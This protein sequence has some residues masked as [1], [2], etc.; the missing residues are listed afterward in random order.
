MRLAA[1]IA[2]LVVSSGIAE[3]HLDPNVIRKAIRAHQFKV[4]RCYERALRKDPKLEGKVSVR[5]TIDHDG[6]VIDAQATGMPALNACVE[7]VVRAIVFPR[8]P[9]P[10]SVT[11]PFTFQ[12]TPD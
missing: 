11:Y 10:V 3:A 4:M 9:G 6:K 5:L 12:P 8:L 1:A 7:R 2:A